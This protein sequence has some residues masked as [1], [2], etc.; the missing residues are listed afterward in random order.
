VRRVY[1]DETTDSLDAHGRGARHGGDRGD[2]GYSG[3]TAKGV[4][5]VV[6]GSVLFLVAMRRGFGSILS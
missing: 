6:I 5:V 3:D 2:S 1:D 4:A